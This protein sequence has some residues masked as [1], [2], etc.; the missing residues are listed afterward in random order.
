MPGAT[1]TSRRER[2]NSIGWRR[3]RVTFVFDGTQEIYSSAQC[4]V[5]DKMEGQTNVLVC[6]EVLRQRRRCNL[7]TANEGDGLGMDAGTM[8]SRDAIGGTGGCSWR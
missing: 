4:S 7:R 3:L 5:I 8:F 6:V 1:G 2:W